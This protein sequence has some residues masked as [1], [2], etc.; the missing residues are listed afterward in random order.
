MAA[1]ERKEHKN[2]L[3]IKRH[4]NA[5]KKTFADYALFPAFAGYGATSTANKIRIN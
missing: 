2:N 1:K 5:Q 3:A 4:K